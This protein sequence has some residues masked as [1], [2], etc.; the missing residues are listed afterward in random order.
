MH[1]L[2]VSIQ[3]LKI[4]LLIQIYTWYAHYTHTIH[5]HMCTPHTHATHT[6]THTHTPTH[7][8]T[9]THTFSSLKWPLSMTCWAW[10]SVCSADQPALPSESCSFLGHGTPG[11][12][13]NDS[14]HDHM[15][16]QCGPQ[17]TELH[18]R[19]FIPQAIHIL[20]LR[21]TTIHV[22]MFRFKRCFIT[23]TMELW[24]IT[25][26]PLSYGR[27]MLDFPLLYHHNRAASKSC[28]NGRVWREFTMAC[29]TK[30]C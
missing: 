1:V 12:S 9:H 15:H 10:I 24:R 2:I 25:I 29:T 22:L 27:D 19:L 13:V 26:E 18:P 17:N 6:H 28:L 7:T 8:H 14:Q 20:M 30:G 23:H 21:A 4:P 3:V 16:K 5:T 11:Q